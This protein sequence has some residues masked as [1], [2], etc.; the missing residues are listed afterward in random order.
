MNHRIVSLLQRQSKIDLFTEHVD[1]QSSNSEP[2]T[3]AIR[4][5]NSEPATKAVKHRPLLSTSAFAHSEPATK[6]HI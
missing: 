1:N 2:A 6:W 4:I 5:P 3:M